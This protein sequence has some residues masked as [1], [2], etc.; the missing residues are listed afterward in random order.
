MFLLAEITKKF[1]KAFEFVNN[2]NFHSLLIRL[3]NIF[4]N[5]FIYK[6]NRGNVL[7]LL[8]RERQGIK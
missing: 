3:A 5:V 7:F 4:I 1:T 6:T 2:V 8:S